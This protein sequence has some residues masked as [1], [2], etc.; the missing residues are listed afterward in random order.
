MISL[1]TQAGPAVERAGKGRLKA[2]WTLA[3]LAPLCAEAAFT[4]ISL[5]SIWRASRCW[6]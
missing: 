2:A 6:C 5:P 3:L 4:G 1:T